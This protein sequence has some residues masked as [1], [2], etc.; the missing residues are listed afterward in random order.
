MA[1]TCNILLGRITKVS[2]YEGAVT[3]KLEKIFIENIPHMELVF[4]EIEGR[5]VPFFISDSEYNGAGIL[6]L[7]FEGYN[8]PIRVS[9][10]IGCSI[11]LT[12]DLTEHKVSGETM[13]IVGFTVY[14]QSGNVIGTITDIIDNPGQILLRLSAGK[15]KEILIPFH[16]NL[17]LSVDNSKKIL[18][19]EIPEGLTEIN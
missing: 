7:K 2:G 14:D 15:K 12:T 3:V 10:F 18:N 16:H 6:K 9:E 4:L 11:F 8:S 5:P 19:M 1:Y 13:D 17:V